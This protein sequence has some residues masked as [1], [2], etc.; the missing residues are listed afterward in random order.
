MAGFAT[1]ADLITEAYT[2]GKIDKWVFAKASTSPEVAGTMHSLWTAAGS[3]R[4]GAAPAGTPGAAYEMDT[5]TAYA[6]TAG[7]I[8]FPDRSTDQKHIVEVNAFT[9]VACNLIVYDRLVGVGGIALSGTGS[10]TVNSAALTRY[11]GSAA[12]SN[13]AWLEVSTVT[14]TTAP[15]LNLNS[16]TSADG[17][18]GLSGGSITFP[19]AATNVDTLIPLPLND[20]EAGVR[21]VEAGINVGTA[22][23]SGV[24]TLLIVRR[25]ATIPLMANIWTSVNFLDDVMT[26][27]RVYDNAVLGLA[28]MSTGT[29]GPAIT[30]E[31]VT[32]YG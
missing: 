12:F 21:S 15:I 9:T 6:S 31:I 11:S 2:N 32:A 3:P 27:P 19:A 17:T 29:T 1:R 20:S 10:K 25:L 4:A 13:E 26:L 23:A 8:Y 7:G 14:A 22:A 5:A 18:T 28:I 30:G 24:A 16:Y